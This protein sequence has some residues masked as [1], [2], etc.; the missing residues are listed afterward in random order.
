MGTQAEGLCELPFPGN[1]APIACSAG[2][3]AERLSARL[4][5]GAPSLQAAIVAWL[6]P[7]HA[8][9]L[10]RTV[11]NGKIVAWVGLADHDDERR[12]YRALLA[13]GGD[14]VGVHDFVGPTGKYGQ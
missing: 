2:P 5:G 13:A 8:A 6:I 3:I 12:A 7:R 14:S 4:G 9:Q 10:Q 11:E 1:P